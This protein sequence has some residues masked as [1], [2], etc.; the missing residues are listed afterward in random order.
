M[1]RGRWEMMS[2]LPWSSTLNA[3]RVN[4]PADIYAATIEETNESH[5][6]HF[7]GVRWKQMAHPLANFITDI[8]LDSRGRGWLGGWG[9]LAYFDGTR[10]K[11][12]P[13]TP[14]VSTVLATF[15]ETDADL[16]IYAAG[17]G[18]YRLVDSSWVMDVAIDT[19][20][21]FSSDGR[22]NAL[23]VSGSTLW[24]WNRGK[25][26]RHSSSS[27]LQR[28]VSVRRT[29]TGALV[30]V[31]KG[32]MIA[33]F[34]DG[35]WEQ[36]P[37]PVS[38]QLNDIVLFSGSEGWIVGN[39][40]TILRL[41]ESD[42]APVSI[43]AGFM[44]KQ[45]FK[46]GRGLEGEYGVAMEDLNQ[47]GRN[48][49]YTVNLYNQN[50]LFINQ[51]SG[52]GGEVHFR[53][54]SE[55]RNGSGGEADTTIYTIRDIDQGVGVADID[56]DGDKEIY[57][58]SLVGHN[59]LLLNKGDGFFIDVSHQEGRS[60][61]PSGRTN[62]VCFA[63]A[64]NDGDLD[65]FVANESSTNRLFENNGNG[66]FTDVTVSAGLSTER[67]GVSSAFGDVDNDG[68]SD[69]IV[70][71]W[72]DRCRLYKNVSVPGSGIRFE[73][74][75]ARAGIGGE[76]YER[77]NGTAFGDI[78]ND[79]DL[80]L[81]IAKRKG[82]NRLFLNDGTGQFTDISALAIGTD[83]MISY[84]VCFAD[85]DNDGFLDLYVSSV[86]GNRFYRNNGGGKFSD[87]T[88]EYGLQ[89]SGYNTGIAAGD[90]DGDG[91]IDVY[92]ATYIDG[93]SA[94]FVNTLNTKNFITVTVEGTVS[95]RDA[96][97]A[98][99]SLYRG[100]FAG[101]REGF[102]Q[103]REIGSG[104]GYSSH[105]ALAV[106]FG[107][108]DGDQYDIVVQF[109]ASGIVQILK[110]VPAGTQ[111]RVSEETGTARL[112]T[113]TTKIVDRLLV[114]PR[115]R[116][117]GMELLLVL[118]LMT[119]SVN[120]G[121][122]RSGWSN[123]QQV[124]FH[125]P[126]LVLYLGLV[127]FFF[128][129]RS[130]LAEVLPLLSVLTVFAVLHLYYERV[131]L[132]RAGIREKENTRKQIARD[133]HDDIAST[134]GS[135]TIYLNVL[136]NSVRRPNAMQSVLLKKIDDAIS[137]ASE[138]MT[139]I[140]WA[141]APKHDTLGDLTARIRILISETTSAHNMTAAFTIGEIDERQPVSDIVRRNIY[142]I[143][144]E[145]MNN[146]RKHAQA[147]SVTLTI[148]STERKLEFILADDGRGIALP[149]SE[150]NMQQNDA[151]ILHGNGMG[152]MQNRAQEIGAV[153]EVRPR[154]G[155]GTEVYL[156]I[157]MMQLHH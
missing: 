64:D 21:A 11:R 31:G 65:L 115:I 70:T 32:G 147:E 105:Q 54:E 41:M 1:S 6:Y 146:I 131:V 137:S 22:M 152:N 69:L 20:H 25:W 53:D 66:F 116:I 33:R 74:V 89:H 10:W 28:A 57:L 99:V 17:S 26:S 81:F 149:A 5:L 138:G 4:G 87:K 82:M 73:E 14:G 148:R 46:S 128:Y 60:A 15:G 142:L 72:T 2:G 8:A 100:G 27:L 75:T 18:F 121:R 78:D 141:I 51:T 30:A 90:A 47:D 49:I 50:F 127:V 114:D 45:L 62:S 118:L 34:R 129:D 133:L 42:P 40:G 23:T 61:V 29:A 124:L 38:E 96:V 35:D 106:H 80:D 120:W 59:S 113:L 101:N 52:S 102:L 7:D 83:T 36:I 132:K 71:F 91:D 56:N 110:N 154:K 107:V 85:L 108:L 104:S 24:H 94:L 92:S 95:N 39:N 77:S 125:T 157:E 68:R 130:F 58:C 13:P 12:Y 97:G 151:L 9:E 156:S 76:P 93:E 98:R 150:R 88:Y 112:A 134:L 117:E 135:A 67:G 19:I 145:G 136:R 144:K 44:K 43:P 155:G 16:M 37:S 84:G 119:G 79:G 123:T 143:M 55:M 109:P 48:D 126:A 86:G 103:M 3:L 122:K 139:D 63:D 140:V 153:F 111:C